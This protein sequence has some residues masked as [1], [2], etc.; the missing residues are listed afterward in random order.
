[1]RLF[2]FSYRGRDERDE[3]LTTRTTGITGAND[4]LV[5]LTVTGGVPASVK[6]KYFLAESVASKRDMTWAGQVRSHPNI[7]PLIPLPPSIRAI[8]PNDTPLPPFPPPFLP[9]AIL[10]PQ[11]YTTKKGQPANPNPCTDIRQQLRSRRPAQ[12]R[13]ERHDD[14]LRRREQRVRDPPPR[15][16]LCA[17]VYGWGE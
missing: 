9:P 7:F 16:E 17:G 11:F 6:V 8:Y 5:A 10:R 15:A 4:L 3:I 14:Q 2:T 12:G 13:P 1:M